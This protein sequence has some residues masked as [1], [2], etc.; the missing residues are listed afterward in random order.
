[1]RG[2]SKHERAALRDVRGLRHSPVRDSA[3]RG[4]LWAVCRIPLRWAESGA[5]IGLREPE[6][7]GSGGSVAK[8]MK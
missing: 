7:A 2:M 6:T 5:A 8:K 1:M 4:K 3:R